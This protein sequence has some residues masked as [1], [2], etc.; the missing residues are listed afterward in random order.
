MMI[1]EDVLCKQLSII[2]LVNALEIIDIHD[3][4]MIDVRW[5]NHE[6]RES[7]KEKFD[8]SLKIIFDDLWNIDIFMIWSMSSWLDTKASEHWKT[9][10]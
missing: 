7:C 1:W 6:D 3:Y 2:Y 8:S 9:Y 10:G 4:V 5:L